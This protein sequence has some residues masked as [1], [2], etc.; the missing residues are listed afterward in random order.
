MP[1]IFWSLAGFLLRIKYSPSRKER[2]MARRE[3]SDL[4]DHQKAGVVLVGVAQFGLMAAA[5]TDIYRHPTSEIRGGK[6]PWVAASFVNFVGP[7]SYFV[8]GRRR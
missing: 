5:L 6:W 3:W 4:S 2:I 8:F 1:W 7:I